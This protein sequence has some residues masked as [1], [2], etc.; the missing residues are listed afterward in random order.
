M[1]LWRISRHQELSGVGGLRAGGR[2]HYPGQPVVYL[3]DSPAGALLEVCVH[4]AAND[5]PPAFTLLRVEGP[6]VDVRFVTDDELPEDWRERIEI[7]RGLGTKW[8]QEG[9]SVLLRVPSAIVPRTV[10]YLLNPLH[11][12]AIMFRITDAVQY[13]FDIRIKK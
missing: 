6:E 1:V 12:E 5:V 13:P 9:E 10:N 7:T 4:T 2:W 3:A 8:L 11:P